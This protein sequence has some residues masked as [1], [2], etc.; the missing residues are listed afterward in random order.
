VNA[1]PTL[2]EAPATRR[3]FKLRPVLLGVLT[4]I[5]VAAFAFPFVWM[6]LTSL[7]TQVENTSSVPVWIFTPT[8]KNYIDTFQQQNFLAYTYHS[9]VIAFFATVIGLILG[10]PAAYS[11]ARYKQQG[12]A[13]A[14]LIARLT[15]YITYVLPWFVAFRALH[16]IDT[17]WALVPTFLIVSLPLIIWLMISFFEDVPVELEEAAR[18]DGAEEVQTFFRIVLPLSGPGIVASAILAFILSWN[19]FLFALALSG[20]HTKTAPVAVFNFLTYG[21]LN[22]GGLAAAALLITLPVMILAL[23]V[24]RWIVQGMTM[25]AVKG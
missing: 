2:R 4:V 23:F 7:R 15:P 9:F 11:I 22:Y 24:Q 3:G 20:P 8:L 14:I 12:L 1:A 21:Q 16:L 13:L 18:V 17:Y 10:L 6:I 5:V 25:G 19:E